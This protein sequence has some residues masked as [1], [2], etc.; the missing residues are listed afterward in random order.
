M[1]AQPF[2][3]GHAHLVKTA[4]SKCD[5]LVIILGSANR[6]QSARNPW[7]YEER[8]KMIHL[9]VDAQ[10]LSNIEFAPLNDHRYSDVTWRQEVQT[11]FDELSFPSDILILFGHSKE[12]NDYLEW[13][14]EVNYVE[15]AAEPG[16]ETLCATDLRRQMW[17]QGC[18]PSEAA[19]DMQYFEDERA[20]F[21]DYPYPETLNFNCA[22]AIVECDGH[23]A[24]IH[25]GGS[26]GKGNWALPGGFKNR[27]ETFLDCAIRELREEVNI[28]VPEKVLRGS[29]V[30][31]KLFDSPDRGEGI[32]RN[33]LAVHIRITRDAN[34]DL[35]RISP[36]DDAM[37]ATWVSI[38]S[39]MNE[40]AMHDDHQDIL[41][42]MLGTSPVPA[43]F[44]P[45]FQ[46]KR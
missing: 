21:S 27:N 6:P 35:P 10:G 19:A 42:V 17:D 2:H 24:L 7:T 39:A 23:V 16:M 41:S 38:Y 25:R 45:R 46:P 40:L 18:L 5:R 37:K 28:R 11:V 20:R 26:P 22:D 1:R 4:R 32:P 15:V 34:G 33:T 8:R 31:T 3:A 36:G 44:N 13:F 43:I 29:I 12:G 14:P 30:S 9:W